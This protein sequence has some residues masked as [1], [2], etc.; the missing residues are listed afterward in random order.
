MQ[1]HARAGLA[2]AEG[3]IRSSAGEVL[4]GPRVFVA[5][6]A[7]APAAC[8]WARAHEAAGH[9]AWWRTPD[10]LE[11]R[12]LPPGARV[13][14]ISVSGGNHD[15]LRAARVARARGALAL[16]LTAAPDAP[17]AVAAREAGAPVWRFPMPDGEAWIANPLRLVALTM[18]AA[19]VYGG[20]ADWAAQ[21]DATA[22]GDRPW[23]ARPRLIFSLGSGFAAPAAFD[24]SEKAV[25]TGYAP[26]LRADVRNFAHGALMLAAGAPEGTAAVLFTT[27]RGRAYAERFA[28]GLPPGM[29]RVVVAAGAEGL[30]GA[31]AL[32]GRGTR[33]LDAALARDGVAPTHHDV[34]EWGAS[35][36]FLA[37]GGPV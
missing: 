5:S 8:L 3:W 6:G 27:P 4:D 19:R 16:V 20:E 28:A 32:L 23:R 24:L 21:L 35:L 11:A 12:P 29:D 13:V 34:P 7:T 36:H 9:A 31:V 14:L 15:I 17:L 10:A 18:G 33:L 22:P 30:A 25:E 1:D 37:R 2:A 26:A